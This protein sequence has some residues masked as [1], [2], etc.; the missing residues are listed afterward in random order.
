MRAPALKLTGHLAAQFTAK[1][2]VTQLRTHHQSYPLKLAKPF[3]LGQDEQLAVYMMDASP[4]VLAGDRYE[5]SW[6]FGEQT[7]VLVTNQSYTKVHPARTSPEAPLYP[8]AQCVSLVLETGAYVEYMPEPLML[9]KDAVL[10]G[11]TE[12]TMAAGSHLFW[13]EIVC[14]GR[15]QRGELFQYDTYRNAMDV[16]YDGELIYSARQLVRPGLRAP[17]RIG[18]WDRYTHQ[19][20]LLLFSDKADGQL[21]TLLREWLAEQY[22]DTSGVYWGVSHTYKHGV[23]VSVL[24]MRVLD[25]EPVLTSA[26]HWLR[27]ELFGKAPLK[28]AK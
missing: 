4:G 25:V 10:L 13:S 14:P 26:W 2:G 12:V 21:S 19:G 28:L 11:E 15:H 7:S 3:R 9:Y 27:Q 1:D 23:I 24:G 16:T 17:Q 18:S 20:T 8:S 22:G 5:L 6:S